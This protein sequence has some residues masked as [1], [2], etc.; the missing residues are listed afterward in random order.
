[1][2]CAFSV[3]SEVL[4][5]EFSEHGVVIEMI[6]LK[7]DNNKQCENMLQNLLKIRLFFKTSIFQME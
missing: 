6:I 3:R 5:W 4:S 7:G 1:M 2:V